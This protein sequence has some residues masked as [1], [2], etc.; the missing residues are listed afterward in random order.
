MGHRRAAFIALVPDF[1][2]R[3]RSSRTWMPSERV[4]LRGLD[5]VSRERFADALLMTSVGTV[6]AVGL[7]MVLIPRHG[8]VGAGLGWLISQ[9]LAALVAMRTA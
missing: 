5:R 9:T 8:I 6:T 7:D 4:P 2:V 3:S 1:L